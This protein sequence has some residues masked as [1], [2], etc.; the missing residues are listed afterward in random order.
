MDNVNHAQWLVN[1]LLIDGDK[2]LYWVQDQKKSSIWRH[3]GQFISEL[4]EIIG[5]ATE[6]LPLSIHPENFECS[7]L[8][9]LLPFSLNL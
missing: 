9:S 2:H 5:S 1:I 3:W 4:V 6:Q 8:S 7:N